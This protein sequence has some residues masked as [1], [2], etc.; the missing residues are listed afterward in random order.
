[1]AENYNNDDKIVMSKY[2]FERL[3][4]KDERNDLW[5]NRI[6]VIEAVLILFCLVLLYLNNKHW[7]ELW[8][9][10]D[11]TDDYSVE[12]DSGEGGDA[13]YIGNNGEIN[14]GENNGQTQENENQP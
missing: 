7:Q 14:Y 5:R 2:A 10:Y 11:Y 9:Q 13:N 6:I 1:M 4:T 8:S 3:Q 12:L